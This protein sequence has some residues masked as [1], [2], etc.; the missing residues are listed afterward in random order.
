MEV[1]KAIEELEKNRPKNWKIILE[2]LSSPLVFFNGSDSE[3]MEAEAL[4]ERNNEKLL[5]VASMIR[6]G[7]ADYAFTDRSYASGVIS[8]LVL[9]RSAKY[10]KEHLQLTCLRCNGIDILYPVY[11]CCIDS[12][13]KLLREFEGDVINVSRK[14]RILAR[15]G[16]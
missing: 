9:H 8:R 16:L 6:D 10:Q 15:A 11:D 5:H 1:T 3:I 2:K 4:V 12:D 14:G 13:T 7:D